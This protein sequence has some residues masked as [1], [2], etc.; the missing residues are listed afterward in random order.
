MSDLAFNLLGNLAYSYGRNPDA[1]GVKDGQ[2]V[3]ANGEVVPLMKQPNLLGRMFNS[4]AGRAM[5]LNSAIANAPLLAQINQ[6][7]QQKT[8]G[9]LVDKIPMRNLPGYTGPSPFNPD[10]PEEDTNYDRAKKAYVA[11]MVNHDLMPSN[12]NEQGTQS[13]FASNGG[14]QSDAD[15]L[16]NESN[17]A[18][19]T[20]ANRLKLE[21]IRSVNGVIPEQANTELGNEQLQGS[22]NTYQLAGLPQEATNYGLQQSNTG[23]KLLGEQARL[24]FT[25]DSSLSLAKGQAQAAPYIANSGVAQA[26][27][28]SSVDQQRLG[29]SPYILGANRVNI[30]RESSLAPYGGQPDSMKMYTPYTDLLTGEV[31]M[32]RNPFGMAN[33][34]AGAQSDE[35]VPGLPGVY[36]PMS[37]AMPVTDG[38]QPSVNFNNSYGVSP[39]KQ[40]SLIPVDE[41]HAADSSGQIYYNQGT[42]EKPQYIPIQTASADLQKKAMDAVHSITDRELKKQKLQ[43]QWAE[44]EQDEKKNTIGSQFLPALGREAALISAPVTVPAIVAGHGLK[45]AAK[46]VGHLIGRAS[47]SILDSLGYE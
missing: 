36:A 39:D 5:E 19:Q 18:K 11:G 32:R 2:P 15:R 1:I 9:D 42:P 35:P 23:T 8:F 44:I 28:G 47:G 12:L 34:M 14:V 4:S 16:L 29:L 33:A 31:S 30:L 17:L 43:H 7:I 22:R 27:L 10:N 40:H 21:S 20:A 25:E 41:L 24:P 37:V 46:G 38:G 13:I 6:N 45:A 26:M 3:N